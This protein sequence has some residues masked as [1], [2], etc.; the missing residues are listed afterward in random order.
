M[1]NDLDE[2]SLTRGSVARGNYSDLCRAMFFQGYRD[3][4]QRHTL[5]WMR[6]GIPVHEVARRT[7]LSPIDLRGMA[8]QHGIPVAPPEPGEERLPALQATIKDLEAQEARLRQ[9]VGRLTGYQ[10]ALRRPEPMS[11][12]PAPR[13]AVPGD[14]RDFLV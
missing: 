13:D 8:K 1:V 11:P 4:M 14:S 10:K 9:E 2:S 12:A 3:M 6:K 7:R 5:Y